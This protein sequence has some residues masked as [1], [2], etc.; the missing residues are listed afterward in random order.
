METVRVGIVGC[1]NIS[2]AYIN[3]CRQ[4]DFLEIAAVTDIVPEAAHAKAAEHHVP[5]VL[6]VEE[7]L[8]DP[9]IDIVINLTV[10]AVH[11][12][13]SLA[14]IAA[15][16]HVY[17][18]K[19]LAISRAD[20]RAILYAAAGRGV[21]VGCA[22]DTFLGGGLQ[23]CR[24]LID[25]GA[26]GE[27][28]AATAFMMGHG[29]EGWHPNPAFFYQTGAGPLFDM[30]PYYV[31]ALVH[32]LGPV[33]SVAAMARISFTERIATS[34]ARRGERLPVNVPT[35]VAGTLAMAAGPLAT[36]VTSFDVWGHSMPRIE[37]YGSEG[38]LSV[39]DPNT[40]GGPVRLLRAGSSAW[41]EVPL[42]HSDTVRRGIGVADM[43]LG[44]ADGTPHRASGELA[45]HILDVMHSF[46]DSSDEGHHIQLLSSCEQPAALPVAWVGYPPASA[47]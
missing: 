16:K 13:V 27:P 6:T 5:R 15:G 40:F 34:E 11:A 46:Y 1:G 23:T 41:E 39:P 8:N 43:A 24:K 4:F 2:S 20:G 47:A 21:R 7:L 44:I 10:P 29:P 9:D 18:E 38:S 22:P 33:Q 42:T 25:D 12:E 31:T 35:H 30:G 17:S 19:P 36:M 37:I 3:G 45:Y 28:V 26:I 14:A 32:L